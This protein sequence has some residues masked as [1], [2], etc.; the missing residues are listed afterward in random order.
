VNTF[1][2]FSGEFNPGQICLGA[3]GCTSAI[4]QSTGCSNYVVFVAPQEWET[5]HPGAAQAS[6]RYFDGMNDYVLL[7]KMD[8]GGT[9]PKGSFD[10]LT[11]DVW[12][13][14]MKIEGSQPIMNEVSP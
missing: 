6:A 8:G 14:W 3:N 4:D 5:V 2:I 12:V 11:V 1:E 10:T 13:K 9:K 7:P